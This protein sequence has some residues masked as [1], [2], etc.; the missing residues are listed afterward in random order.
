MK[1][2]RNK[3]IVYRT[4]AFLS[5]V[6]GGK[7]RRFSTKDVGEDII[8]ELYRA[9][10]EFKRFG[11]PKHEEALLRYM[12]PEYRIPL[13]S[14]LSKDIHGTIYLD[15]LPHVP[16]EPAIG[17]LFQ[18]YA[19]KGIDLLPVL[20]LWKLSL[21]N[22]NEQSRKDLMSYIEKF[23]IPITDS[24]YMILYKAVRDKNEVIE[25]LAYFV[26]Q[27]FFEMKR[28]KKNPADYN[29]YERPDDKYLED[30]L[31]KF[32]IGEAP[33]ESSNGTI[34]VESETSDFPARYE[35]WWTQVP[36]DVNEDGEETEPDYVT[37]TYDKALE[38]L[39]NVGGSIFDRHDAI[40]EDSGKS[41][42]TQNTTIYPT[43]NLA[44]L[45]RELVLEKQDLEPDAKDT[46]PLWEPY[47]RGTHGMEIRL[48]EVVTM[49]REKCDSDISRDCSYGLHVGSYE[50]VKSFGSQNGTV[51]ACLVNPRDIVA[52]PKYDHSKIR[53]CAYLP[54]GIIKKDE[55]G[56]W[57]EAETT[58]WEEAFI[59]YE[60]EE[61]E[62]RIEEL[63]KQLGDKSAP[64]YLRNEELFHMAK[65]RLQKLQA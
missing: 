25:K 57:E 30:I 27:E 33:P 59:D 6:A 31:P 49:P 23:G 42:G 5:I 51:L 37:E 54:Y 44:E 11:L 16:V 46:Q 9:A 1:L 63:Q 43:G 52:L 4:S 14:E 3:F 19:E 22:P 47:H 7:H 13:T 29:V 39:L 58:H 26:G 20:N 64:N 53:C 24:G 65:D 15:S 45:F 35:V 60:K 18:E 62:K 55:E 38:Y 61:L 36:E 34:T 32:F 50:Y 48:G 41:P 10:V 56:R 17:R 40:I 21:D 2:D 12:D 28:Q 8:E